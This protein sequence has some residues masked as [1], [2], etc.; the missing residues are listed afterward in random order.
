MGAA[1]AAAEK[2]R[3]PAEMKAQAALA[4]LAQARSELIQTRCCRDLGFRHFNTHPR[5]TR[6][7]A[8][9]QHCQAIADA[10]RDT[11]RLNEKLVRIAALQKSWR[12]EN[13]LARLEAPAPPQALAAS[14]TRRIASLATKQQIVA[15]ARSQVKPLKTNA[16]PNKL[17]K[18][19]QLD[20]SLAEQARLE[21]SVAQLGDAASKLQNE[22]RS[23][24]SKPPKRVCRATSALPNQVEEVAT[25]LHAEETAIQ[26]LTR[27]L[28]GDIVV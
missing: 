6:R 8:S 12:F 19:I 14:V 18:R 2:K 20:A 21:T 7:L 15:R 23:T 3:D 5:R 27:K 10:A 1:L 9:E 24:S 17:C 22:L 28:V 16:K 13:L 26:D 4:T 11:I 25:A